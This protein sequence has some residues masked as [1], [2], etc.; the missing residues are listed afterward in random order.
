MTDPTTPTAD[1]RYDCW[2]GPADGMV[3]LFAADALPPTEVIYMQLPV[4]PDTDVF[5]AAPV[6]RAAAYRLNRPR[7]GLAQW[8]GDVMT[9]AALRRTEGSP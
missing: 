5:H 6:G 9:V 1:V 2:A 7:P 3:L 8:C 4:R